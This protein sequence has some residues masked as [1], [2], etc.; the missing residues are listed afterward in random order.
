MFNIFLSDLYFVIQDVNIASYS[1]T[2]DSTIYQSNNNL[3]DVINGLQVSA[4]KLFRW[5]TDKEMKGNSDKCHL[6]MITNN[7]K[8]IQV[9][10]SL[11]KTSNYEK[12]LDI[13]ID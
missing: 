3:D 9:G 2:D 1:Y 7:A 10:E 8:E 11:I 6:I 4:K 12:L 13:K 5:F